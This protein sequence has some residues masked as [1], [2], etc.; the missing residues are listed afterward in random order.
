MQQSCLLERRANASS[1]ALN[2]PAHCLTEV[3]N[4]CHADNYREQNVTGCEAFKPEEAPIA[5]DPSLAGQAQAAHPL[6]F[7]APQVPL[8]PDPG[9]PPAP[10]VVNQPPKQ[11]TVKQPGVKKDPITV[12]GDPSTDIQTV[13]NLKNH[14]VK[15]CGNPESCGATSASA[16]GSTTQNMGESL[17][18]YC[19][20]MKSSGNLAAAGSGDAADICYS[21]YNDCVNAA[22]GAISSNQG[23]SSAIGTLQN[24]KSTC[25][26]L[27]SRSIAL[28][29][30]GLSSG[31]ASE[32]GQKCNAMSKSSPSGM[33]DLGGGGGDS[34]Q[35]SND[36]YG[37]NANP[38]GPGCQ[39]CSAD[40]NSAACKA[41]AAGAQQARGESG[42]QNAI[43]KSDDPS[44]F[45]VP[46]N[47]GAMAAK[48]AP[49]FGEGGPPGEAGVKPIA[50]NSGGGIPGG[51]GGGQQAN[52]NDKRPGGGSGL[53]PASNVADIL[54]GGERSGGYTQ[55][56]G[57]NPGDE[58]QVLGYG[59]RGGGNG[60]GPANAGMNGLDLRRYLPGGVLDPHRRAAGMNGHGQ[61]I[62]GK[63]EDMF[64][65][66][67]ERFR[68]KCRLGELLDCR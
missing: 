8:P 2:S 12:T 56:A 54:Q 43:K 68:E 25:K 29:Q 37:C 31:S 52:L 60:R 38:N 32:A 9:P 4:S 17:T 58:T 46:D 15:C 30:S 44:S 19:D 20:R 63:F 50:N 16:L 65:H 35:N 11:K 61:E 66:I 41:L 21:A 1:A 59:G 51:S 5:L 13:T 23:D 53:Q 7:M 48:S 33:P 26:G 49:M 42:F 14:A 27:S 55:P 57:G 18:A 62:A 10:N 34:S 28:G 24:L 36:A 39:A 67:S 3:K 40:P 47:S 6:P 45:D 64:K 22:D